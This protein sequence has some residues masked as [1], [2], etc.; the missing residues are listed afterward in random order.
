MKGRQKEV[1]VSKTPRARPDKYPGPEPIPGTLENIVKALLN[2]SKGD[3][4]AWERSKKKR[5]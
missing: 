1:T 5:A 3:L 4:K 2:A